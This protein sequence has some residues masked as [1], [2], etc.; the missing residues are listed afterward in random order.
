MSLL[1]NSSPFKR[2]WAEDGGVG[3]QVT[4]EVEGLFEDVGRSLD[5]VAVVTWDD[6]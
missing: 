1:P 3:V 6:I 4:V 2:C 5:G